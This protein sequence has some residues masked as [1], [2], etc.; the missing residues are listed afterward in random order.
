[1]TDPKE[2]EFECDGDLER[3]VTGG[4]INKWQAMAITTNRD[5]VKA[6][7]RIATLEKKISDYEQG[8]QFDLGRVTLKPRYRS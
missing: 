4:T 1:M 8:I 6:Q 2:F 7:V 5:L 3:L